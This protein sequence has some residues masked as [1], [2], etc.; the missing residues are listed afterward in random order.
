VPAG[1]VKLL[2]N[3]P[4]SS[5]ATTM[6]MSTVPWKTS[7]PERLQEPVLPTTSTGRPGGV[8]PGATDEMT[9]VSVTVTVTVA[10]SQSAV[11]LVLRTSSQR[12]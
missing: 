9:G 10:L 5:P 7:V 2:A 6:G 3:P 4:V 1:T 11:P 12:L 8:A